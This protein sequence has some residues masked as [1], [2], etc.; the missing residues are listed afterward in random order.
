MDDGERSVFPKY[1]LETRPIPDVT[2][3]E[4]PPLPELGMAVGEVVVDD[5]LEAL[6]RE[7]K[8]SVRTDVTGTSRDEYVPCYA[9]QIFRVRTSAGVG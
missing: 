5:W 9:A 7:I 8:A 6:R 2:L 4:G 1:S 3:F